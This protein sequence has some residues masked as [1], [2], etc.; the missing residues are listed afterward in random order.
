MRIAI[1]NQLLVVEKV[2][3]WFRESGLRKRYKSRVS[4]AAFS[5][6][7]TEADLSSKLRMT[8]EQFLSAFF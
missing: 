3:K 5:F 7:G 6:S 8:D 1:L 2:L 4:I